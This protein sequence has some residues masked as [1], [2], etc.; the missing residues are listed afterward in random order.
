MNRPYPVAP[1]GQRTAILLPR[2]KVL[3]GKCDDGLNLVSHTS[4]RAPIVTVTTQ[5]NSSSSPCHQ[6]QGPHTKTLSY[7]SHFWAPFA[8]SGI[9][10]Q[11]AHTLQH[12]GEEVASMLWCRLQSC[13]R[14]WMPAPMDTTSRGESMSWCRL[15]TQR[16]AAK[17]SRANAALDSG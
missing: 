1:C 2:S 9:C 11:D 17:G 4:I 6:F 12:A 15:G 14:C 7:V 13:T 8:G 10:P 5:R 3:R 16:R